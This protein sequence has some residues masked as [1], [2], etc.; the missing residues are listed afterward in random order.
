MRGTQQTDCSCSG[1]SIPLLFHVFNHVSKAGQS[2][3]Q[4]IKSSTDVYLI[5][6]KHLKFLLDLQD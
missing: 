3:L 2:V 5:L 1:A 4:K 6:K